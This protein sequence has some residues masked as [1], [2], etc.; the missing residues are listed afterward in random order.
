MDYKDY[1]DILGVKRD[2]SQKEIKKAYRDLARKHH[3]DV[4]EGDK[5]AET[6]F[7]DI[8]EAYEVLKDEEKRKKYD[9]FGKDW[10]KFTQ[11]GGRPEDFWG[12]YGGG[13][14]T[15]RTVTPEE[16]EQM[17]SAGGSGF[18]DFFETLFG[19]GRPR[20]MGGYDGGPGYRQQRMQGHDL[21]HTVQVTL[22]EAFHGSTR[23]LTYEDGRSFT[24]KI[25]RGVTS[26]KRIRF[27]GKG[28]EGL[29]GGATGD[30]FLTIDVQ[31]DPRFE[32]DDANL[33]T[34]ATIDLFTALLGGSVDVSTIDKT[35]KLT[36]PPETDSG[37]Q[38]RLRGL[39]M[40]KL[41]TP[42]QRGDLL[43]KVN[44]EMPKNLTEQER[45]LVEQ[46]RKLRE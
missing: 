17:F 10:D 39:G 16:F 24:A 9:R 37:K 33:K 32:R 41:K 25:P 15:T 22:D 45:K 44:V 36:I 40:P 21:E 23:T 4:N 30:L 19:G 11:N 42:S 43:V 28:Q 31:P 1:Y 27:R 38:F 34:T 2:A 20:N 18:S 5:G 8:N 3:P 13:R 12:Q 46:L 29:G 35:V 6:R 14:G 26:G 7:K